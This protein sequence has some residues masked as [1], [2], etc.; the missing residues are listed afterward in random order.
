MRREF[1]PVG[2]VIS[3]RGRNGACDVVLSVNYPYGKG[4]VRSIDVPLDPLFILELAKA[5]ECCPDHVMREHRTDRRGPD[6]VHVNLG[7]AV[8]H[9]YNPDMPRP[10]LPDGKMIDVIDV[11]A[12][13]VIESGE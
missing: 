13:R 10:C 12:D 3:V 7:H 4:R 8:W 11:P 9:L 2:K 5:I 6:E 1:T